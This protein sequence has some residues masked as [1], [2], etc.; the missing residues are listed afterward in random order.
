MTHSEFIESA[1]YTLLEAGHSEQYATLGAMK[2]LCAIREMCEPQ[3][4]ALARAGLCENCLQAGWLIELE[5]GNVA[6]LNCGS[7]YLVLEDE[8]FLEEEL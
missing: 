2:I 8:L 3:T 7:E 6:C 4:E 1:T 5:N